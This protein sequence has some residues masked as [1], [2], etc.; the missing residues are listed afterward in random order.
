MISRV[1]VSLFVRNIKNVYR[2]YAWTIELPEFPQTTIPIRD[3]SGD[4]NKRLASFRQERC[5]PH[6]QS[7][8][9]ENIWDSASLNC[10][11]SCRDV[12]RNILEELLILSDQTTVFKGS[13]S[14][15]SDI[16]F[17][18]CLRGAFKVPEF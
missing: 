1:I 9:G 16:V 3:S 7:F 14:H 11:G 12:E 18:D 5:P 15:M 4:S 2:K 10:L 8:L 6:V 13:L 17:A